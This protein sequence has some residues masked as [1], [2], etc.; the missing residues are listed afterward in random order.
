M[1]INSA[2]QP[3]IQRCCTAGTCPSGTSHSAPAAAMEKEHWPHQDVS[4]TLGH[5]HLLNALD[6]PLPLHHAIQ[7]H[8]AAARRQGAR[9]A[10][11]APAVRAVRRGQERAKYMHLPYCRSGCTWQLACPAHALLLQCLDATARPPALHLP[12]MVHSQL[13]V[14]AAGHQALAIGEPG[15]TGDLQKS[16]DRGRSPC[17]QHKPLSSPLAPSRT[18]RQTGADLNH[19]RCTPQAEQPPTSS[20]KQRPCRTPT[21]CPTH[22]VGVVHKHSQALASGGVPQPQRIL[23]CTAGTAGE[24]K[25]PA[26]CHTLSVCTAGGIDTNPTE[27]MMPLC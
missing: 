15:R 27:V 12:N 6:A 24:V 25:D 18:E 5:Q 14:V 21:E 20:R 8:N 11:Q 22:R 17:A 3:S 7:V 19:R 1:T 23:A 10:V 13:L 26:A 4:P 9:G 16:R 2:W